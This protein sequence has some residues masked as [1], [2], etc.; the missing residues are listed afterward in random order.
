MAAN[1]EPAVVAENLTRTFGDFTAVDRV[2]FLVKKGEIFGFLGPNGSGKTTT[3]RMLCGI[4]PPSAGRGQVLG[5]D[6]TGQTEEVKSRIGYMSQKFSLYDDLTV[7]ENLAFFAGLYRVPAGERPRRLQEL[8]AMAGLEGRESVLLSNLSGGWRQ[9]LALGCAIVHRPPVLFLDEPTAGVDPASRRQFWDLIYELAEGGVTVFVTTHYMDEAEHCHSVAL[10]Y[11]GRL[12][13]CDSPSRLRQDSLRGEL[14]E[15]ACRPA[16][17]AADLLRGQPGVVE[18][19]LYG[20]LV[21]VEL[22][23]ARQSAALLADLLQA[24]GFAVQRYRPIRPSLE[25]AFVSLIAQAD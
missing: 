1:A 20:L 9:R 8:V 4:L 19:A 18:A 16:A 23:P 14:W 22:D 5:F 7:G 11:G 13:A 12:I 2:S 6:I 3:I 21:H 15:F 10:M 24:G 17:E 25:D